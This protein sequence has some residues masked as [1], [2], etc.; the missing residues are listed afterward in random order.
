MPLVLDST[1]KN[2]F[3]DEILDPM[4]SKL[5]TEFDF[6][7]YVSPVY[8]GYGNM[9]VRI[10]GTDATT[11]RV[12]V[13]QWTK[14]YSVEIALYIKETNPTELFWKNVYQW[15]ERIYELM[16]DNMNLTGTYGWKD[17]TIETTN[18]LEYTAEEEDVEHLYPVKF[19]WTGKIS[20][21]L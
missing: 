11:E 15:S 16:H 18:F 12:L 2:L 7:I 21:S 19:E 3:Y 1:Y 5:N 8:L 14:E 4:K 9:E 20:A 17:G 6:P 10:W 13:D